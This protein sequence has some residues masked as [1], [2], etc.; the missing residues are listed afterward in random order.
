MEKT[1]TDTVLSMRGIDKQFPGVQALSNVN[2]DLRK[3][4]V[5]ALLGENGAGKS[6]L[7]KVLGGIYTPESG[8]IFINGEK[9]DITGVQASQALGISIIHQELVLV[10]YLTIAENIFLGKEPVK[11]RFNFVDFETMKIRAQE[12]LDSFG[13]D[14]S[15]EDRIESLSVAQ[16]QM[17]E[18]AKALSVD[19]AIIVM[20]E[21]TASL[22]N[23]ETERLFELIEDLRSRGKAVVYI[24]HRMEELF[25]ISDRVTVMRDGQYI[26][27]KNT[28][29]TTRQELIQMMVGRKLDE[30]FK[31]SS[32]QSGEE[33]LRVEGLTREGVFNDIGFSL[34]KGEI[35]GLSGIVGAGRTELARALFGIDPID[36]G[37]IILN[38]KDVKISSP[39]EAIENGL[40]LVPESRKEQG[41]VLSESV[42]FNLTLQVLSRFI[43]LIRVNRKKENSIIGDYVERLSIK[44]P[45]GET[46]I[47]SLSGGNQQKVVIAKWLATN[48]SILILD[49][50]TR[51]VDVNAKMEIYTLINSLAEQGL[52][53]ILISSELPEILN[54]SDRVLVMFHGEIKAELNRDELSQE[55][56][57]HY[58]T[59]GN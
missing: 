34:K 14:I 55:K 27:T 19:A 6:T 38:G 52:A 36:G 54:M 35:L 1:A 12:V 9:A 5:H 37:K 2:F 25:R 43:R 44:T 11:G 33:V 18:I 39:V 53:I 3:G 57:M 21:P 10:P 50:P 59:G 58:A 17:V 46:K 29:D 42:G 15:A 45:S 8:D 23:K 7:M 30:F 48:P 32:H 31:H 16:Q 22:T 47:E 51:G 40:A 13:L 41:L 49:E 28:A 20:D 56:I 26:G 4:E 24:S